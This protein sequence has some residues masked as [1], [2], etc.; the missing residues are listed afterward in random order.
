MR[1]L[2]KKIE[3]HGGGDAQWTTMNQHLFY[4][5]KEERK[6]LEK[7]MKNS[8]CKIEDN[9]SYVKLLGF[10]LVFIWPFILILEM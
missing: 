1:W 6:E 10:F 3:Q 7:E 2:E 8:Q 5:L 4:F 9:V